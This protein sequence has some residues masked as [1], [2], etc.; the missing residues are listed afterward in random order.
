MSHRSFKL[1]LVHDVME[2]L[3]LAQ[4]WAFP[5]S[6]L[7]NVV[8]I[9]YFN[10]WFLSLEKNPVTE[11]LWAK[12]LPSLARVKASQPVVGECKYSKIN[13]GLIFYKY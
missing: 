12:E 7:T 4:V 5:G 9:K 6:I 2:V 3:S 1:P 8:P 10:G 11:H 13:A